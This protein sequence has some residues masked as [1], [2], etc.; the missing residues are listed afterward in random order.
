MKRKRG[1]VRGGGVQDAEQNLRDH[2]LFPGPP[3]I[4]VTC[5]MHGI[6]GGGAPVATVC[7]RCEDGRSPAWR[8]ARDFDIKSLRCDSCPAILPPTSTPSFAAAAGGTLPRV[9]PFAGCCVYSCVHPFMCTGAGGSAC[10]RGAGTA[11]FLGDNCDNDGTDAAAAP[12][13]SPPRVTGK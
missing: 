13:A 3:E 4:S 10:E 12:P 9:E 1:E 2:S 8:M 6:S 11:K 7:W 5:L